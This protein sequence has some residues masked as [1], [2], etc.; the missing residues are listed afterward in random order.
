[1]ANTRKRSFLHDLSFSIKFT[2]AFGVI[3]LVV[4]IVGGFG[5]FA[6]TQVLDTSQVVTNRVIPDLSDLA[7]I[8]S[9]IQETR[10][11]LDGAALAPDAATAQDFTQNTQDDIAALEQT[12][13]SFTQKPH[14]ATIA[15]LL[16]TYEQ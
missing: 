7:T 1:M 8:R 6:L 13:Q 5:A 12:Y 10:S 4:L 11:D 9:K 16:S 15:P 3:T 2:A 14:P